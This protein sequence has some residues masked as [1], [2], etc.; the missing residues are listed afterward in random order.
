QNKPIDETPET[1][2]TT[3]TTTTKKS[4]TKTTSEAPK[5]ATIV[6]GDLIG[7]SYE[8]AVAYLQGLGLTN[9]APPKDG[10]QAIDGEEGLVTDVSPTGKTEFDDLITLTV[11]VPFGQIAD[12]PAPNVAGPATV[13]V[14]DMFT[15][16]GFAST[17]PAGLSI[18]GFQ[19]SF[20]DPSLAK[21]VGTATTSGA[22]IEALAP[23]ELEVTYSY[24]C[25]GP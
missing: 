13:Q 5:T 24:T 2:K 3:K 22:Q 23:G 17:C 21:L 1:T 6:A 25:D 7:K 4:P 11:S 10:P 14:N 9:I 18:G 20:N 16:Q 19:I 15:V 8:E 12:P